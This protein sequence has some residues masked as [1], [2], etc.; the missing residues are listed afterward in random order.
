[1]KHVFSMD[2]ERD[3]DLATLAETLVMCQLKRKSGACG[4]G[5]CRVCQTCLELE[6]CMAQLPAC[7][8][9][10]VKNMAQELY[11]YREFQYGLD[12]P[13]G[14]KAAAAAALKALGIAAA[15]V[16]IGA[17][18][19]GAMALLVKGYFYFGSRVFYG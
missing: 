8:S 1:M 3:K 16:A 5:A 6:Q 2:T 9:L 15:A 19:F 17:L 13:S 11:G 14:K 10:R 7:D 12:K 18:A 4:E